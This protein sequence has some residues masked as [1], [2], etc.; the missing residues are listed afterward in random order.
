MDRQAAAPCCR[1]N[2]TAGEAGVSKLL[3]IERDVPVP[4]RGGGGYSLYE[5]DDFTPGDSRF[6]PTSTA[7]ESKNIQ[8]AALNF[9]WRRKQKF[10]TRI[11]ADGIR[12][13]RA[14]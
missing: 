7:A 9:G 6:Y 8:A 5:F 14:T 10:L 11:A 1:C 4:P 2:R 3:P 13:W 12:V